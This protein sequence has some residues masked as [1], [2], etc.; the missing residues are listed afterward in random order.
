MIKLNVPF[1]EKDEAK[2]LGAQWNASEKSWCIEDDQNLD[3][4]KKWL[5]DD[6][7]IEKIKAPCKTVSKIIDEVKQSISNEYETDVIFKHLEVSSFKRVDKLNRSYFELVEYNNDDGKPITVRAVI[8]DNKIIDDFERKTGEELKEGFEI[9]LT[10]TLTYYED[11]GIQLNIKSIHPEYNTESQSVRIQNEIIE[12]LK[13]ENI[14]NSQQEFPREYLD[15]RMITR[16]AVVSP[17]NSD[18]LADF[19]AESECLDRFDL[20]KFDYYE[21]AFEGVSASEDIQEAFTEILSEH[22]LDPFD[23]IVFIRG[24]GANFKLANI[25]NFEIAKA[26]STAPCPV[27]VGVG[28]RNDVSVVDKIAFRAFDT[29]SKV[30]NY[31]VENIKRSQNRLE[32]LRKNLLSTLESQYKKLKSERNKLNQVYWQEI[33]K[34]GIYET[35][36]YIEDRY[37]KKNSNLIQDITK[38]KEKI[39]NL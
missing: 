28:H 9:N 16:V 3:D 24:G 34:A 21:A 14:H 32:K 27:L 22:E 18:G 17:P 30:S 13:S 2:N 19:K 29:P 11:S 8:W 26:I 15:E 5:P 33:R 31:I 25:N 1:K 12:R 37:A 10:A 39:R 36:D 6:G 35:L 38:L 4:F 20:T 7:S 23:C